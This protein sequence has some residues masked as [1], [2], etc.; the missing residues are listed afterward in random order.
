MTCGR[1]YE[2]RIWTLCGKDRPYETECRDCRDK[3][4]KD[5]TRKAALE[6]LEQAKENQ[7]ARWHQECGVPAL[8][9]DKSFENFKRELQ[10]KAYDIIKG[11][12]GENSILIFSPDLYG[13][14]K[15]HLVCALVNHILKNI[16]PASF[17]PNS[18]TV[19]RRSL[20]VLFMN[21]PKLL[22]N[23]RATF[24]QASGQDRKTDEDIYRRLLSYDLLIIDDVGKVR[25][26][27][28]SFLQS[29]YFRMIDDRYTNEAPI[30]LTT[31]LS[32]SELEAHIGGACADRLRE[33]CGVNIVK[34]AGASYR[35]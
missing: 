13:V 14:G 19:C 6:E 17:S 30:I 8:F 24:N 28:Y 26:R 1:Q 31:N 33:M 21:E 35:K 7:R 4:L 11:Y 23:I 29:V 27:D 20:P 5:E 10:P 9:M 34:M 3:R 12:D 32:L 25:P 16:E 18:Y 2:A 15:T 22:A